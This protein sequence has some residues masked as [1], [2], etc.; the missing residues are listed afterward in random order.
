MFVALAPRGFHFTLTFCLV[1]TTG[2]DLRLG[3][4]CR[5]GGTSSGMRREMETVEWEGGHGAWFLG[6]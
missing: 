3:G 4:A 2:H 5:D 1:P 6:I